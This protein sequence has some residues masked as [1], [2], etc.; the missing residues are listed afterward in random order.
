MEDEYL[1]KRHVRVM[2]WARV[3]V[4]AEPAESP[5]VRVSSEACGWL[6]EP[7][8]PDAVTDV[9][10][11]FK[12]AAESGAMLALTQFTEPLE[13]TV[14]MIGFTPAD[15]TADDVKAATFHAV[16]QAIGHAPANPPYIDA[17]GV[18]FPP[19]ASSPR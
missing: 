16:A 18:H 14:T 6:I 1:L 9:P 8:G 11:D 15:T 19:A 10:A 13:V 17:D 4:I 2:H 7:Y 5:Q 3:R 12:V